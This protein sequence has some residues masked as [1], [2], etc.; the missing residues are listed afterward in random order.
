MD[1]LIINDLTHYLIFFS[2]LRAEY[3]FL[4]IVYYIA[5]IGQ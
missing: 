2:N 1:M 4:R 5:D 3:K